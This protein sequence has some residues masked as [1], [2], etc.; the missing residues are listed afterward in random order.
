MKRTRFPH[1]FQ[2]AK[3]DIQASIRDQL[4]SQMQ[5]TALKLVKNLFDEEVIRL[6]GEKF[7][8]K[9]DQ[10]H[11]GGSE[12]GSVLVE[13]QRVKMK[14]PRVRKNNKEVHLESYDALQGFD[15]LSDRIMNHMM[16]G[17]S[18]RDYEPLVD[19]IQSGLKLKKS[20]VSEA[21][22]MG[23]QQSLDKINMRNL[24]EHRFISLMIDGIGFSDRTVICVLGIAEDG[25]K[26]ILGLREGDTENSEVCVDLLQS[27][28]DRGLRKD[29]PIIFVID[30]SKALYKSISKV[31]GS[32]TPVQRCIR[33]KE[34]NIAGYISDTYHPEFYRRWKSLHGCAEYDAA[35][36]EHDKLV[37]WLGNINHE[38]A[39]SL[40]EGSMETLTL[41]KLKCPRLLRKTLMS[42][43]PI[44]SA[45]SFVRSTTSRIKNWK[46]GKNQISRWASS[47]LLEAEKQFRTIRGFKE[48]PL[49]MTALENI[50]LAQES[51]AA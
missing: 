23:S 4:R 22:K 6:C 31:F 34:R 50:K 16:H 7:S 8:H 9:T 3:K 24:S 41:I 36:Q 17:V 40:E 1:S 2:T 49:F 32:R 5:I 47:A 11:R 45:F 42:T 27:L 10:C 21:F 33:H 29:H 14:Q 51:K 20:A 35:I 19:E 12:Q 43:N 25:K 28:I 46:S 30:G 15:I 39:N 37:E 48:I 38:A 44:E 18:T 26:L 13:G